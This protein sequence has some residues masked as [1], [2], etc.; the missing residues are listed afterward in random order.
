MKRGSEN[1]AAGGRGRTL[2]QGRVLRCGRSLSRIPPYPAVSRLV[3][4][5]ARA[6]RRCRTATVARSACY[7]SSLRRRLSCSAPARSRACASSPCQIS[8]WRAI[9]VGICSLRS[10]QNF[11]SRMRFDSWNASG[12]RSRKNSRRSHAIVSISAF[13]PGFVHEVEGAALLGAD[14][15][16]GVDHVG[17]DEVSGDEAQELIAVIGVGH[18]EQDF[19]LAD[20]H[21]P[22][23]GVAVVAGQIDGHAAADGVALDGADDGE[24]RFEH[25]QD[26]RRQF[27]EHFLDLGAR[28]RER[29]VEVQAVGEEF[30]AAAEHRAARVAVGLCDPVR[31]VL[32]D[33]RR[34]RIGGAAAKADAQAIVLVLALNV[35]HDPLPRCAGQSRRGRK[36]GSVSVSVTRSSTT[37]TGSPTRSASAGHSTILA[38]N[39]TP[40]ASSICATA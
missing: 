22:R 26:E 36:R 29:P 24:R 4:Q 16:A 10:A 31:E 20:Q 38:V 35:G 7:R 6:G 2:H 1:A 11:P 27:A 12:A 15:L 33:G 13:G 37:S 39:R 32:N 28:A 3:T 19:R 23:R 5:S 25:G 18:A 21:A 9:R 8:T 30:L 14:E 40:S 34:Q 17:G